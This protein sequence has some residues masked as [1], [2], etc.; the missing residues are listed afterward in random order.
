MSFLNYSRNA[1]RA[2]LKTSVIFES[3]SNVRKGAGINI[4]KTGML[5]SRL[6]NADVG[7]EVNLMVKLPLYP[8]FQQLSVQR[9]QE[10]IQNNDYEADVVRLRAKVVRAFARDD[11]TEVGLEFFEG[12]TEE[13][14]SKIDDYVSLYTQNIMFI[15]SLF[16]QIGDNEQCLEMIRLLS[17]FLGYDSGAKIAVLRQKVLHDYQN[18]ESL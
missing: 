13:N 1:L 8:K 16:E 17:G 6:R 15:I 18:L 9:I 7:E 12:V 5:V 11:G 10:I 3:D 14:L 2:P 4:S